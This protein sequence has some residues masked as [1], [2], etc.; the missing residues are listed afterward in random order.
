MSERK[1]MVKSLLQKID[2]YLTPV[3]FLAS[4]VFLMFLGGVLHLQNQEGEQ[5]GQAALW[6]AGGM[7]FL[8]PLFLVD[9]LLHVFVGRSLV[10]SRVLF[11][12]VPPLRIAAR[13]TLTGDSIWL[14]VWG[15]TKI[16]RG[17]LRRM[18]KAFSGPMI[19][20]AL[21]MLPLLA[22]ELFRDEWIQSNRLYWYLVNAGTALIWVAFAFEFIVMI[23]LTEKKLHY[24]K[25]HWLDLAIICLPLLAGARLLRL[26]R[27]TRLNFLMKTSRV[28]RIRLLGKRMFRTLVMLDVL[29]FFSSRDPLRRLE[30][31]RLDL[32]E[33]EQE[34]SEIRAEIHQLQDTL[35]S[36]VKF[37]NSARANSS[38]QK[39]HPQA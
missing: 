29:R 23:S 4:I 26:G 19:M 10:R 37:S 38:T 18:E 33:K 5:I 31:L 27:L 24:C 17:L 6:C 15:W 25:E 32:A 11:C 14:P 30:K 1:Q 9:L 21:M 28:Y 39:L 36:H 35:E 34:M 22:V 3:M 20:I 12:L 8:Y 13:D 2:H 16:D 7:A